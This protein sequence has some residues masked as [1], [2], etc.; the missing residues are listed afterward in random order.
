MKSFFRALL[1]LAA[2]VALLAP[3]R[4]QTFPNSTLDNW[5]VRRTIEA[6]TNWQTTDD[7]VEALLRVRIPTKRW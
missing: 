3:A 5:A 1:A 7:V 2:G 6:P 4:A